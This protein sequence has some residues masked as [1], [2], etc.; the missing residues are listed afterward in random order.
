[1]AEAALTRRRW[2]QF[3]LLSVSVL[4]F[5]LALAIVQLPF[6]PIK[7]GTFSESGRPSLFGKYVLMMV[8]PERSGQPTYFI[9]WIQLTPA[10][11]C[12]WFAIAGFVGW[13]AWLRLRAWRPDPRH[14]Q[15]GLLG[16]LVAVTV[17]A[18]LIGVVVAIYR[19]RQ[20]GLG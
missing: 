6:L 19:V 8:T 12:T 9:R 3:R 10:F 14:L 7:E 15:F 13:K 5:L 4:A 1:M 2:F 20:Y 16:M 11:I 17:A 18:I